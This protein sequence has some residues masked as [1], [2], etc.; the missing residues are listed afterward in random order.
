MQDMPGNSDNPSL[1]NN[2]LKQ[3]FGKLLFASKLISGTKTKN[4]KKVR[5][6]SRLGQCRGDRVEVCL[7]IGSILFK[8]LCSSFHQGSNTCR[9]LARIGLFLMN[10]GTFGTSFMKHLARTLLIPNVFI[11]KYI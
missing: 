9:L 10:S 4:Q 6:F 3:S 7:C 2:K 5:A 1:A 8:P 11:R